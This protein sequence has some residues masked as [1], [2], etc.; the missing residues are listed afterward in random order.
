MAER[1]YLFPQNCNA[2][3]ANLHCHTTLSDGQ[4]TPQEIKDAYKANGYSIVAFTDHRIVVPH[5]ELEDEDFLPLT[6]SEFDCNEP[7]VE[8]PATR[9]YH[10][11]FI[12]KDKNKTEFIPFT[13]VHSV[14][15]INKVIT[16]AAEAGFLCQYNHPRWS[17]Q[18]PEDF[19]GLKGLYAFEVYN[20]GCDM[21]LFSGDAEY[22]YECYLRAGNACGATACD[23]N[24]KDYHHFG[25][26]TYVYSPDLEYENVIKALENGDFYASTGPVIKDAYV[27]DGKLHI[28]TSPCCRIGVFSESRASAVQLDYKGE[29]TITEAVLD[30]SFAHKY[31]RIT[32]V[33][34]KGK[35][36]CTRAYFNV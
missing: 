10:L 4:L 19:C 36:A 17:M 31:L 14:E 33:D 27:E 13:R 29:D 35:K 11:N 28:S 30:V 18:K 12:S 34:S 26:C 32:V 16:D 5:P 21:E 7:D 15:G 8:W 24:H 20:T 6:A 25:G 23:D 2:Y 3:K 22:E 1:K 9:T